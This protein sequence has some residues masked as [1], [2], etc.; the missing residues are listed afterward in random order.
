MTSYRLIT[1]LLVGS[2]AFSQAPP[3][4]APLVDRVGFPEGYE[5]WPVWF[6]LD[7]QDNKQVRTIY[8]NEM[9]NS[10]TA[11]T[12]HNYP[13]DSVFVMETWASL[14]DA[15]TNPILD[16][17]GRYQKDPAAT[18]TIFVMKKGKGFG[19]DYG[20]NRTGEWEYT[21]YRPDKTYQ[22]TPQNSA[23]CAV[24][25]SVSNQAL[26]WVFRSELHFENAGQGPVTDAVIH[27]Y[28]FIP[29]EF[30]VKSGS[31]VSFHN[32]DWIEHTITD[33]APGGGTTGRLHFGNTLTVKFTEKGE[34]NFHCAIHPVMRGKIIV[35]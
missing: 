31:F 11:N 5:K 4:P 27:N 23:A 12:Q 17:N 15:A 32:A 35:E 20:V 9:A 16:A 13:Y 7:R 25:H 26:D 14:K 8:A 3:L 21:A 28:K 33:D 29:G 18:P 19:V 22:T 1:A 2:A 30:K 24:C 34:F 10:A 6:V